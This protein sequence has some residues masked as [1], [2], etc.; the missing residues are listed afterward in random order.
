MKGTPSSVGNQPLARAHHLPRQL[1]VVRFVRIEKTDVTKS[2]E[3]DDRDDAPD[4]E[5]LCVSAAD[6][7]RR[8]SLHLRGTRRLAAAYPTRN[9]MNGIGQRRPLPFG[10]VQDHLLAAVPA[11]EVDRVVAA[12][13]AADVFAG[14]AIRTERERHPIDGSPFVPARPGRKQ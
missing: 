12:R 11:L 6:P 14:A 3:D 4:E 1:C 7:A 13:A 5:F 8:A 10:L 9:L 2:P